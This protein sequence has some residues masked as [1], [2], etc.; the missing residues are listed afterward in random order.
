MNAKNCFETTTVRNLELEMI[1]FLSSA[2]SSYKYGL[3]LQIWTHL[4][5]MDS[6]YK[7]GNHDVKYPGQFLE[8][9]TGNK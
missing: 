7:Y 1:S 9:V 3:I 4:T 8:F 6:S 2:L 5:N